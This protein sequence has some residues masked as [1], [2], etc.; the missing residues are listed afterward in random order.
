MS[1]KETAK[2]YIEGNRIK[3]IDSGGREYEKEINDKLKKAKSIG[4][5][6]FILILV[7]CVCAVL[8]FS[9]FS[10][11]FVSLLNFIQIA[12]F[13]IS[14]LVSGIISA[15]MFTEK[16]FLERRANEY[17]NEYN[18]TKHELQNEILGLEKVLAQHTKDIN[19][20]RLNNTMDFSENFKKKEK[21]TAYI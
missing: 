17:I 11:L 3:I 6:G 15:D 21:Q 12:F 19:V 18:L 10:N 2:A 1:K 9:N 20:L 4:H 13:V 5:R 14:G 8:A 7:V 16:E